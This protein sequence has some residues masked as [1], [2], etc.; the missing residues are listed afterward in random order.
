MNRI[1]TPLDPL[2]GATRAFFNIG[3]LAAGVET[4]LAN[5]EDE[6]DEITHA[7]QLL[8]MI[9]STAA[10]GAAECDRASIK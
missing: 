3:S 1:A 7:R 2:Q 4:F 10:Q 5:V 9:R 8:G 6:S